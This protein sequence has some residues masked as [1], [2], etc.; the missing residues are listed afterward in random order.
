MSK[1]YGAYMLRVPNEARYQELLAHTAS[2]ERCK[3]KLQ[4]LRAAE[5]LERLRPKPG[6]VRSLRKEKQQRY[7]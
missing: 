2:C 4:D 7:R 3:A 6:T 5:E 1:I